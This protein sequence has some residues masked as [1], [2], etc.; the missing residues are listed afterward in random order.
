MSDTGE[1]SDEQE[2]TSERMRF[3]EPDLVVVVN[4]VE[5]R[6]YSQILC[7]NCAYFDAMMVSNM[8]ERM[9][10]RIYF[11]DKDPE[12]WKLVSQFLES[13]ISWKA[14]EFSQLG[15]DDLVSL[16]PWFH[17]LGMHQLVE[18]CEVEITIRI[19]NNLHDFDAKELA[20]VA[21]K[22]GLKLAQQGMIDY[23]CSMWNKDEFTIYDAPVLRK[24][25]V[26]YPSMWNYLCENCVL[27]YDM[28]FL[29]EPTRKMHMDS[30]TLDYVFMAGTSRINEGLLFLSIKL[31]DYQ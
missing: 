26:E 29:D 24:L 16:V 11:P 25:L 6:H 30:P 28:T 12:A 15:E 2:A 14:P 5:S 17:E 13:G 3:M 10:M 31:S 1:T 4:N 23:I 19:S 20:V 8:K 27:P 7:G 22:Y 18:E 21:L 9:E